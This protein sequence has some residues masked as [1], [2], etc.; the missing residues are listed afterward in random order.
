MYLLINIFAVLVGSLSVFVI[1]EKQDVHRRPALWLTAQS[2]LLALLSGM[3][4]NLDAESKIFWISFSALR[5]VAGL[6][7]LTL[8]VGL[9]EKRKLKSFLRAIVVSAPLMYSI[10]K[11]ACLIEGCCHGFNYAGPFAYMHDGQSY[12]PIQLI[13]IIV[14]FMLY[15]VA[16][17]LFRHK[18]SFILYYPYLALGLKFLL[19]FARSERSGLLF[20]SRNQM[21]IIIMLLVWTYCCLRK[22]KEL[23]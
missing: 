22:G 9:L 10:A 20:L 5:G 8:L 11:M 17:Y 21:V 2:F 7:L 19:D 18:K 16:I 23:K 13:E 15:L 14:F 12:F 1:L 4:F 3:K 6:G